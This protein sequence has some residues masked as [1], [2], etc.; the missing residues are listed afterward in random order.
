MPAPAPGLARLPRHRAS[1]TATL[2]GDGFAHDTLQDL[3]AVRDWSLCCPDEYIFMFPRLIPRTGELPPVLRDHLTNGVAAR[4]WRLS[5]LDDHDAPVPLRSRLPVAGDGAEHH[6]DWFADD[7]ALTCLLRRMGLLHTAPGRVQGER[8]LLATLDLLLA[9]IQAAR[10]PPW[11]ETNEVLLAFGAGI[12]PGYLWPEATAQPA[13]GLVAGWLGHLDR[14]R[15]AL[16]P[17]AVAEYLLDAFAP[18]AS[19]DP[20]MAVIADHVTEIALLRK[21]ARR[22]A[23]GHDPEVRLHSGALPPRTTSPGGV[24]TGYPLGARA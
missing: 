15:S 2:W 5:R 8:R 6:R 22:R 3:W 1:V 23:A 17:M 7:G 12:H 4:A 13:R 21:A 10:R 16:M 19:P 11:D 18:D 24:G 20:G 9:D 14:G